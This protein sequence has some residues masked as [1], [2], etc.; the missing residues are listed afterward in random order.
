[1]KISELYRD[2]SDFSNA[3]SSKT[4]KN[5]VLHLDWETV[6]HTHAQKIQQVQ[7]PAGRR[8]LSALNQPPFHPQKPLQVHNDESL[9]KEI[10]RIGW[11]NNELFQQFLKSNLAQMYMCSVSMEKPLEKKL[12]LIKL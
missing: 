7:E 2:T 1:M 9:Q 3:A 4:G 12:G 11:R 10:K 5:Y 8:E 6:E